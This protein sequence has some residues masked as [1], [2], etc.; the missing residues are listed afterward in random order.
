M[1]RSVLSPRT[2]LL[3]AAALAACGDSSNDSQDANDSADGADAGDAG[4]TGDG[5]DAGDDA[6]PP[7]STPVTTDPALDGPHAVTVT[8][9]TIPGATG[10]RRL[11]SS[12]FATAAPAPRPL[13]VISPGF[14]LD[15]EQYTSYARHLAT[16]GFVVVLTDYAGGAHPAL[17]A[18]VPA[19]IDWAIAE[20]ALGVDATRIGLAGHSLGGR[21]SVLAAAQD[22]RVGAIVAWDPV[23]AARPS[24]APELVTSL[25]APLAVIGET[26]NASG[27]VGDRPCAPGAENF[28]QFYAAAPSPALAV[29]VANADHMDWVDDPTCFFCGFCTAGTASNE[30]ARTV[31]RR[32]DVAWFRRHLFADTAM[33]RWLA[34][35]PELATGAVSIQ[36]R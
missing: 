13:V 21:I 35:P 20:V 29:T 12:I 33:D 6:S 3:A 15:R 26:T 2:V 36:Q 9:A 8:T 28:A 19:V 11:P 1:I 25:T 32:V 24:A 17:A 4:D 22:A 34:N 10:G 18:D 23:D 7:D 31:S 30:V 5:A 14:Q 16:W 27:G